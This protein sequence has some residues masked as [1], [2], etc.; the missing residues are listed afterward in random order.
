MQAVDGTAGGANQIDRDR[1]NWIATGRA[2]I[3]LRDATTGVPV[4]AG[5]NRTIVDVT[6]NVVTLDTAG[7]NVTVTANTVVTWAGNVT[8]PGNVYTSLEFPGIMAAI[9][10]TGTYQ[11]INRASAGNT[12]WRSPI[13]RGSTPGTNELPT[14]DRVL[15][16][17]NQMAAFD[18][19][20]MQPGPE[21]HRAVSSFGV[22]ASLMEYLS[23]GIRYTTNLP[24][25]DMA[26]KGFQDMGI[27]LLNMPY[28][29]D[30][31]AAHCNLA[32][33]RKDCLH[34]I[35]PKNKLW[36]ILDFAPGWIQGIWSM[37]N[38]VTAG[39]Y[40]AA[41]QAFLTGQVGFGTH[42]P[43]NLGRL[44]DIVELG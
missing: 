6:G 11:N 24:S 9:N 3:D 37:K 19:N 35:K 38:G 34:F 26:P 32:L 44:D 43:N 31:H 13:V 14:L 16:L 2:R 29:A 17:L 25:F 40:A 7:G 5:T 12:F 1:L 20:G 4:A 28:K 41:A 36:D 27:P 42:R 18:D 33:Y 23:P 30:V 8:S 39:S 21:T 10:D 22:Q 15:K